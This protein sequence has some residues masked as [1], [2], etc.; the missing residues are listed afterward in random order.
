LSHFPEEN[1]NPIMRCTPD[2]VP[3]YAN[4]PARHWLTTLGWQAGGPLPAA[5]HAA[6]AEAHRQD[7]AVEAEINN[8]EGRTMKCFAVQPPGED[9]INLYGMDFTE[10]KRAEQAL[11][12][13]EQRLRWVLRGSG[14]GAWDWDLTSGEAW[15]SQ[16]MY[17][18]WG[19]VPGT[20][21]GLDSS[22]ALIHSQDRDRLRRA[23]EESITRHTDFQCEFR[24]RH[25]VH[26][27]RWMASYGRAVY[28]DSGRSDRLLGITLDIT[29]RKLAQ[30]ALQRSNKELEQFAYVA[31]HDLQEPLRAVVGF[32]QIIQ[33][34]YGDQIDEKGRHF[35]ERSVQAGNR[36]QRLIRELLTLSRVT[37]KGE[38]FAPTDL[39]H[40]VKD[41]LEN[42][43]TTI[44]EKNIKITC[45]DLPILT[46]DAGQIQRLFQ[47]L[48]MNAVKYNQSPKPIIDID[49]REQDDVYQFFVKDNGI[50]ISPEFHQR[51]FMLFQRLHTES[52]YPGTGLGLALCKKIIERHCGKIWVESQGKEGST[53]NFTLPK[54]M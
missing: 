45:A 52:E 46:V 32:L 53:F 1:P 5:V 2:G 23:V 8:P 4:T 9:Y 19:V 29:E 7:N 44:R 10:R 20:K 39:N 27:E 15:W 31:S 17:E 54:R 49:C 35:I 42:L 28:D 21:M 50:G 11:L 26:G 25:A 24:I 14:G 22:L 13:S 18:L 37:S 43:Q 38:T 6:V 16:E 30:E 47:N 12:A 41:V 34:R 48:I 40:I 33:S 51:I 3:L 36:M